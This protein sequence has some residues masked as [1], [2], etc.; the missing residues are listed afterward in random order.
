VPPDKFPRREVQRSFRKFDDLVGD[1]LSAKFQTWGDAMSRLL[2]HCE[3]DPVMQVVTSPL[4]GDSR[5]DAQKWWNEAVDSVG[6][7]VGS[8][9]YSL[10]IDDDERMA[11]LYQVLLLVDGG[12]ADLAQFS[13]SVYG[14]SRFQDM[15]DTFN[16]ELVHKFTREVSYRLNEVVEDIGDQQEVS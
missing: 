11:L 10:P 9:R 16:H 13:N 6:G 5:V 14:V 15:V 8:G 12:A 2:A 1:L 7:M 4:K 3:T